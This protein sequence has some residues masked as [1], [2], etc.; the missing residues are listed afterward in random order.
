ME[1][2]DD[3]NWCV[4][5]CTLYNRFSFKDITPTSLYEGII[6]SP[7]GQNHYNVKKQAVHSTSTRTEKN[8][9]VSIT[10]VFGKFLGLGLEAPEARDT[11]DVHGPPL[12]NVKKK[13]TVLRRAP[14]ERDVVLRMG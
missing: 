13:N 10:A 11:I 9:L 3:A 2:A 6:I 4:I 1:E 12:M 14:L 8:S 5:V 7:N